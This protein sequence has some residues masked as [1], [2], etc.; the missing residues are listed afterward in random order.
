MSKH[1]IFSIALRVAGVVFVTDSVTSIPSVIYSIRVMYGIANPAAYGFPSRN[2]G[3][4]TSASV[5]ALYL[6]IGLLLLFGS[7]WLASRFVRDDEAISRLP[8]GEWQ[9]PLFSLAARVTGLVYLAQSVPA[10]VRA[11]LEMTGKAQALAVQHETT[12][13][14]A[15]GF[16]PWQER[17]AAIISC[18]IWVAISIYLLAGAT[19]LVNRLFGPCEGTSEAEEN[20][21]L[22]Q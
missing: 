2:L 22:S 18:A 5:T 14:E 13:R 17:L 16:S 7:N 3:I 21:E 9:R 10:L 1:G 8:A 12:L 4:I 15:L 11:V 6:A 20:S 19:G